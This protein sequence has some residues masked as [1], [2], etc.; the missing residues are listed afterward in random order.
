MNEKDSP[1][2]WIDYTPQETFCSFYRLGSP[3]PQGPEGAMPKYKLNDSVL[4]QVTGASLEINQ[5]HF[6]TLLRNGE[7]LQWTV[8]SHPLQLEIL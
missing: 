3:P 7:L 2:Q 6:S 5:G 4:A 1:P 8:D